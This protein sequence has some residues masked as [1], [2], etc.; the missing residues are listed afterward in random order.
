M[1]FIPTPNVA[2]VSVEAQ[3]NLIPVV[4]T[5]W[6]SKGAPYSS[7][8]LDDLMTI[9]DYDWTTFVLPNLTSTYTALLWTAYAQDSN[10]AP[11]RVL[12]PTSPGTG[13]ITTGGDMNP[14]LCLAVTFM[15]GARGRSGRG[16]NYI[17]PFKLGQSSNARELD[18]TYVDALVAAY[19]HIRSDAAAGGHTF[20]VVSHFH[21]KAPL[22][23]GVARPVTAIDADAHLD[24]I[25]RRSGP[26]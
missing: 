18:S 7:G 21:D 11:M 26:G 10:T 9:L 3:F 12:G 4:N 13:G 1:S 2:R 6:F 22:S 23:S 5:M 16:R 19:G 15:T 8:D 17:G 14:G 20:C 25:R 24:Y